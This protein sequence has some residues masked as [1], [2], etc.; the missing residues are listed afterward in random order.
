MRAVTC[1]AAAIN[2]TALGILT[3]GAE[4]HSGGTDASGCHTVRASG[5]R[6]CHGARA[7]PPPRPAPLPDRAEVYYP[8]CAAVRAAGAAPVRA[9]EPGYSRR[10][11]RD[12]DG[13]ACE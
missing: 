9:G 5:E 1:L 10:L 7:A 2:L 8:N 12:G 3:T 4:A 6:H 11:D 13:T